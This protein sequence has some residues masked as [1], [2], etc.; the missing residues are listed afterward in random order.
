MIDARGQL[1]E[2]HGDAG[3]SLSFDLTFEADRPLLLPTVVREGLFVGRRGL[4][5]IGQFLL[6]LWV[7][8]HC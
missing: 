7:L 6:H 4:F 3:S 8:T 1:G 2:L 5:D